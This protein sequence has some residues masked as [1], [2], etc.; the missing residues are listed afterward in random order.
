MDQRYDAVVIGSGFGG[1]VT[2]CRLAQAGQSVLIL[3]RGRRYPR[4]SF[5]R[6]YRDLKAGWLWEHEQGLF[7]VRPFNE[8]TLVQGAG[9]GGGSLIYANVHLRP[10]A[11]LFEHGWPASYTRQALDP[12]YDLAAY[13]L[14]IQPITRRTT[15]PKKTVL[16]KQVAERLERS[17]Q[18]C[19]PNLAINLGPENETKENKFGVSQ[20]SCSYCG[21]CDVGCNIHAKNT[22]DLN[23]LAVAEQKGAKARTRCEVTKIAPH[24]GAGYDI[25]F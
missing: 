21:E 16:M 18:F 10:P 20:T 8:V 15:L 14:D 3:E 24:D 22:L 23:Y 9:Y 25:W 7:D 11:D 12:Y 1:A 17:A 4:H 2:A 19:Y 5:P 13:M 6:N